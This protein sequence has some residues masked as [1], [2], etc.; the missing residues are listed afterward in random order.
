MKKSLLASAMLPLLFLAACGSKEEF[1][2]C[3][4]T[5]AGDVGPPQTTVFQID[6]GDY[7]VEVCLLGVSPA[8]VD[9]SVHEGGT[10]FFRLRERATGKILT[11][12]RF[13]PLKTDAGPEWDGETAT[14]INNGEK[15]ELKLP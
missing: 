2:F 15:Y 7:V 5:D 12:R 9:G 11:Q 6:D 3:Q 13:S 8:V 4:S 14:F 1:A 10:G